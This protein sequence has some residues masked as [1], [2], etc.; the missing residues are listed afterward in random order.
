VARARRAL[1]HNLLAFVDFETRQLQVLHDPLGELLAGLI[2]CVFCQEPA[3]QAAAARDREADREGE[4]VA[5]GAV[6]HRRSVLVLFA[7]VIARDRGR[8]QAGLYH[9]SRRGCTAP[10]LASC[11]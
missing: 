5:K 2:R 10:P 9:A 3:Q 7:P 11:G 6:I 8:C 1:P 4:L